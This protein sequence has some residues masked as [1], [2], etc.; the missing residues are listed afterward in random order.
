MVTD[1]N[2]FSIN[3]LEM[4]IFMS[5]MGFTCAFFPPNVLLHLS[6]PLL[7]FVAGVPKALTLRGS[8]RRLNHHFHLGTFRISACP[9]SRAGT[10][11]G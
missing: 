3:E 1:Y 10:D 6:V 4:S 9:G 8:V 2:V 11:A 7:D 5:L